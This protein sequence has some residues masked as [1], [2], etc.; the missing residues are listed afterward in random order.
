MAY[1]LLRQFGGSHM[2][3][4][5]QEVPE[6]LDQMV[7]LR[8]STRWAVLQCFGERQELKPPAP[9]RTDALCSVMAASNL[10]FE[11]QGQQTLH[12]GV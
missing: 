4:S 1:V 10:T 3:L 9:V 7:K 6:N 12:L 2:K 8:G 11:S 5:T